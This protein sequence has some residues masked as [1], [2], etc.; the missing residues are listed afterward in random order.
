M[1]RLSYIQY[2][3]N[4][5][6]S[7][8]ENAPW[9]IRDHE[10]GKI[11]SSH[12]T[13]EEAEKHLKRMQM[14]KHLK[15][16]VLNLLTKKALALGDINV[17]IIEVERDL[18]NK[19]IDEGLLDEVTLSKLIYQYPKLFEELRNKVVQ[20]LEKEITEK[21]LYDFMKKV[22]NEISDR[23]SYDKNNSRI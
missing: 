18:L 23:S 22:I 5:K 8:G 3:K 20:Y 14:F 17:Q 13:K 4:H 21:D 11:L 12:K 9:V 1:E 2:I 15:S 19:L 10:T 6:N 16:I 7:K